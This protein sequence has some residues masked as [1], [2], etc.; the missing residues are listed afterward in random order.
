MF[1]PMMLLALAAFVG[2][3]AQPPAT[4]PRPA[5]PPGTAATQVLGQYTKDAQGRERYEGG[6]W[7]EISYGRPILRQR[8]VWGAGGDYGKTLNAGAPVWRAGA[9]VSTRLTT[10]S[11]LEIGG[12]AVPAGE[13]SLFIDLK[14]PKEW[15]LI[16]SSWGAKKT[17]RDETPGTLWGSYNYTPDKDVARVPMSVTKLPV[18]VDQL[19][20]SFVDVT[21]NGG[22]LALMW[23][24]VLATAPFTAK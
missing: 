3:T 7:I 9:N 21:A 20:W 22:K 13:Y 18:S 16:V 12:K 17:G 11:P 24:D 10:E 15:T 19:T 1:K 2:Q 5:S 23:G 6:K 14:S 4:P 8:D